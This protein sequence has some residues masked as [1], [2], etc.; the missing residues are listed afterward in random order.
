MSGQPSHPINSSAPR[1]GRQ[2]IHMH[3]TRWLAFTIASLTFLVS[4]SARAD[5][6]DGGPTEDTVEVS[7]GDEEPADIGNDVPENGETSPNDPPRQPKGTC[8]Y[9]PATLMPE[10]GTLFLLPAALMGLLAIRRH[11]R[12]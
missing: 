12:W 5:D 2:E 6:V 9:T 1:K 3:K 4:I 10:H 11:R 7:P 8:S